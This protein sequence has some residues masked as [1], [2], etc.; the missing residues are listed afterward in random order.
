MA[1]SDA[2]MVVVPNSLRHDTVQVRAPAG[3][4]T[5][6]MA[7]QATNQLTAN[8]FNPNGCP[9]FYIVDHSTPTGRVGLSWRSTPRWMERPLLET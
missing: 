5:L 6:T 2:I 8:T 4:N 1:G 3:T 7:Q 9:Y